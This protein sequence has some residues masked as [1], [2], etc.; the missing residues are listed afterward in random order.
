[1]K[2]GPEAQSEGTSS[3][4]EHRLWMCGAYRLIV[5]YV[6]GVQENCQSTCRLLLGSSIKKVPGSLFLTNNW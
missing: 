1:M 6:T 4:R 2:K 3:K 5:A